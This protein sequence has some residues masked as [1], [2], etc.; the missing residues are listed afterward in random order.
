MSLRAAELLHPGFGVA[1]ADVDQ[2]GFGIV[3]HAVPDRIRRRP[4]CRNRRPR[5]S[6]L[7]AWLRSRT[8]SAGL[9]GTV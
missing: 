5:F 7:C 4:F 2:V 8:A 1:G 9:P 3:R 6:P